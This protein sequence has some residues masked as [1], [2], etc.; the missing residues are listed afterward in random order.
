[1]ISGDIKTNLINIEFNS[2]PMKDTVL[3][4]VYDLLELIRVVK[5]HKISNEQV[6]LIGFALPKLTV[7]GVAVEIE[8][9]YNQL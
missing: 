5:A 9:Q 4:T 2:S 6:T 8:V 1:M 7:A 3:K